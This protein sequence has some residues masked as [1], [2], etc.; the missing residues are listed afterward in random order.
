MVFIYGDIPKYKMCIGTNAQKGESP[1][2]KGLPKA[3]YYRLPQSLFCAAG[4]EDNGYGLEYYFCVKEQ[5]PVLDIFAVQPYDLLEVG[6][7]APAADLP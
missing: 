6:Y 1:P 3:L 4:S 5:A 2:Q 7:A